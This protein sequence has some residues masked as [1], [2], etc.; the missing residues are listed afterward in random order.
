MAPANRFATGA[1]RAL[2]RPPDE[3]LFFL[4]RDFEALLGPGQYN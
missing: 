1:Q 2:L 4:E 3:K